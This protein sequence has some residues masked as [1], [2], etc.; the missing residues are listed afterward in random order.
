LPTLVEQK[1]PKISGGNFLIGAFPLP[2]APAQLGHFK[3]DQI[4]KFSWFGSSI[5]V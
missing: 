2:G 3:F 1:K 5:S 4:K